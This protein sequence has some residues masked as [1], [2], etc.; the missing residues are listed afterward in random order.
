MGHPVCN[1]EEEF[2]QANIIPHCS[3]KYNGS[4]NQIQK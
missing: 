3:L 1:K 2:V 4:Q